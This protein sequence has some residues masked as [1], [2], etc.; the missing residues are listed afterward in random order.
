MKEGEG[1]I[2]DGKEGWMEERGMKEER[3]EEGEEDR[4]EER[5]KKGWKIR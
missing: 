2:N 1:R 5:G 3:N 4:M